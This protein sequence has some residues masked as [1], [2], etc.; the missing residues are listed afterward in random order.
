MG[1]LRFTCAIAAIVIIP[2]L[3][4]G[5]AVTDFSTQMLAAQ[6][7]C[8]RVARIV[9]LLLALDVLL[10]IPSSLVSVAAGST[11]GVV[12]GTMAIW[13]GMSLGSLLGY[14][15]GRFARVFAMRYVLRGSDVAK[16]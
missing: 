11:L 4:W 6:P 14:C 12:A 8:S 3:L 15:V 16:L 1:I 2:F 7:C 10:P 5:Q 13:A 9:V